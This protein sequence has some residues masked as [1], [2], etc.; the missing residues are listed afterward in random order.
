MKMVHGCLPVALLTT[1]AVA[2]GVQ[3]YELMRP[4]QIQD[5]VTRGAP[6]LIPTGVLEYHGPQNP[7]GVDALIAQGIAHRVAAEVDCVV[8]PTVFYGYTGRWAGGVKAGEIHL[9]GDEL[10]PFVRPMLKAFHDQG[11][12]RIYIILHH[13]GPTGVTWLTY[14]RAAT[15]LAME[16]GHRLGGDGWSEATNL[17]S[18]LW[19][20]IRVVGD[21][22]F[23]KQGYGGHGG[24]GE[25]MAMQFLYPET[26]ALSELTPTNKLPH[27][28][29]DAG[30]ADPKEA[31]AIGKAII[32]GWVKELTKPITP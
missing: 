23:S 7:I 15:E 11:W 8:A 12:K 3:R 28:A 29:A 17:P 21:A 25:T 30:Q 19:S 14:Q 20:R 1:M 6:L 2:G 16:E 22:A 26:V 31:E 24:K 4:G 9:E 5:A 18:N 32:A 13:Q 27:W 10:Y